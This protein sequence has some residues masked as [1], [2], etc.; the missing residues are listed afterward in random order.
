MIV[1]EKQL[2]DNFD[3]YLDLLPEEDILISREGKIIAI[4]SE[5]KNGKEETYQSL[6]G[7]AK[8]R[9]YQSL[10]EIKDDRLKR[11]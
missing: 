7:I 9:G 5:P 6:I 3:E 4:I 10:D 1:T 8:D 11:Q 2:I